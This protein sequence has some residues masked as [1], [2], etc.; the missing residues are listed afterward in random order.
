[1]QEVKNQ[2]NG[3]CII[4][5]ENGFNG[6]SELF[7]MEWTPNKGIYFVSFKGKVKRGIIEVEAHEIE[8]DNTQV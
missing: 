8:P 6:P 1:M 5:S 2:R 7:C 4:S 3:L